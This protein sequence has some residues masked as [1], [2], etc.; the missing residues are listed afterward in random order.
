MGSH[1][2]Y[3]VNILNYLHQVDTTT[4]P[5]FHEGLFVKVGRNEA[6]LCIL[7][8]ANDTL[9]LC[10]ES[11]SNVVTMK[12]ILMGFELASSLKINFHKSKLAGINVDRNVLVCYTNIL[13]CTQME[14]LSSI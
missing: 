3:K 1:Y 9:F 13:N 11:F 4:K 2:R 14:Y 8:F 5:F 10:K 6:E 12:A 7:Q